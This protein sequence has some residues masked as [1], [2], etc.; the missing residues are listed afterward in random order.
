MKILKVFIF[1]LLLSTFCFAQTEIEKKFELANKSYLDG[2]FEKAKEYYLEIENNGYK[3]FE[4]YY[5]LGNT[6][7]KLGDI[8]SA[9]LYYERA[10]RI[11]PSDPDLNFNLEYANTKIVD[12]IEPLGEFFLVKWYKDVK[13]LF[14]SDGW[15]YIFIV[16]I[17][18]I[19]LLAILFFISYNLTVRKI[20]FVS[21]IILILASLFILHFS[22]SKRNEELDRN[23]AII[24]VPSVYVKSSPDLSS[25]DLF[26]LHEGTKVVILDKVSNWIKI[27]IADGN[28][29][30]IEQD[31]VEVI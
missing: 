23:Q 4:L 11:N 8:P 14:S 1:L 2:N 31:K 20:S 28:E 21:G 26:I 19:A 24:F 22:I 7:F 10:K 3:F 30:W 5:N 25:T 27:Q 16:S 17:W 9:I 15:A 18:I 6:F 13:N 12:K 29:G